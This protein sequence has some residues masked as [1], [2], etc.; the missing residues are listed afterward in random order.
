M[1]SAA[2]VWL[3]GAAFCC[4]PLGC[5]SVFPCNRIYCTLCSRLRRALCLALIA[6]VFIHHL[7]PLKKM[8]HKCAGPL[9]GPK[10]NQGS[11]EDLPAC[12][13]HGYVEE[14]EYSAVQLEGQGPGG[15]LIMNVG[16][17]S[18]QARRHS[19]SMGCKLD[20]LCFF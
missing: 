20:T 14:F 10:R 5:V 13:G 7:Y 9:W 11:N 2:T 19:T 3:I 12:S 16:Q 1:L 15:R 8:A 4:R 17:A 18:R 6:P